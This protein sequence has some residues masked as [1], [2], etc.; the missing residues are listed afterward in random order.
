MV[1]AT[2]ATLP[3]GLTS[4]QY[5]DVEVPDKQLSLLVQNYDYYPNG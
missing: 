1:T 5:V 3:G 2:F 4:P